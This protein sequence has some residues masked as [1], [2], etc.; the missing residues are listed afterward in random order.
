MTKPLWQRVEH[1]KLPIVE[2]EFATRV[3]NDSKFRATLVGDRRHIV[4]TALRILS[5]AKQDQIDG[6]I[7]V[8]AQHVRILLLA[9]GLTQAWMRDLLFF[10]FEDDEQT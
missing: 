8:N 4:E 1:I 7:E 10:Q 2:V 3:W 6:D 5:E 9:M